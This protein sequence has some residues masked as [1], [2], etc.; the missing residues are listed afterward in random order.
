MTCDTQKQLHLAWGIHLF[1]LSL[2]LPVHTGEWWWMYEYVCMDIW[3]IYEYPVSW[4]MFW[5]FEEL[6]YVSMSRQVELIEEFDGLTA[7]A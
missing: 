1:T 2:V 7:K 6:L 5:V 3:N 4:L